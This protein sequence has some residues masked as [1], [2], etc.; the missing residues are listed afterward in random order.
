MYGAG[1][2]AQNEFSTS[3]AGVAAVTSGDL[4][5]QQPEPSFAYLN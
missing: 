3:K 5:C 1:C 2:W 4:F